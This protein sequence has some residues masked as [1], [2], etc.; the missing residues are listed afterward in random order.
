MKF[1][2]EKNAIFEITQPSNAAKN[3][4]TPL[5]P[6]KTL[7]CDALQNKLNSIYNDKEKENK[8]KLKL[9]HDLFHDEIMTFY[10]NSFDDLVNI[11]REEVMG[12]Y[13][14]DFYTER[15]RCS[16]SLLKKYE[17]LTKEYQN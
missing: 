7:E 11:S 17:L 2:P 5:K 1:I 14:I 13:L 8:E 4:K 3:I 10:K 9:I 12:E 6:A 15:M 16:D